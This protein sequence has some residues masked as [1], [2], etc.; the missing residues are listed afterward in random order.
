MIIE[1]ELEL[2]E[3]PR[4]EGEADLQITLGPVSGAND[5]ATLDEEFA[6]N[7]H[8]GAFQ[9]KGGRQII[10][11]PRP[12]V[13]PEGLRVILLG[14]IMAFL[15]RQRGWLPLHASVVTVCEQGILFLGPSG[16]GKSTAAAAFHSRGHRVIADDIGAVRLEHGQCVVQ[17]AWPRVRL[18]PDSYEI[19]GGPD[20]PGRFQLDKFSVDL[21]HGELPKCSPV[22]RIYLLADGE[23][24]RTETIPALKAATLLSIHSFVRKHRVG[25]EVMIAH[26]QNC[27]GTAGAVAVVR[28]IRPRRLT[29]LPALVEFVEGEVLASA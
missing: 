20:T 7:I 26:L 2:P 10:V 5:K 28:L 22:K 27:A 12:G 11:D 21:Q 23:Q 25:R 15:L 4:G 18:C 24:I 17:P 9:I 29:A 14:R 13:D 6:F 8:A 3:L 1:S 16:A 19:V